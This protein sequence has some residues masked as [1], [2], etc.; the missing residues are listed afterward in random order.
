MESNLY[1]IIL[2]ILKDNKKGYVALV[3][4]SN[5][6]VNRLCNVVKKINTP[7]RKDLCQAIH[8]KYKFEQ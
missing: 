6:P 3:I 1:Y 2:F 5:A 4:K 8:D 7:L